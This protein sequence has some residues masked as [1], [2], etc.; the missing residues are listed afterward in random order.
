M[1]MINGRMLLMMPIIIWSAFS[2]AIF[3]SVFVNLMTRSMKNQNDFFGRD[4]ANE[5]SE[6]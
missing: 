4:L 3:G 6:V 1:L 5:S 2:L